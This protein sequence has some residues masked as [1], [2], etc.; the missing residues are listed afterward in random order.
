MCVIPRELYNKIVGAAKRRL[1]GHL[2]PENFVNVLPSQKESEEL[3]ELLKKAANS[4]IDHTKSFF[5][6]NAMIADYYK[7]PR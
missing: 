3:I 4:P 1:G 2:K 6:N 5:D 7:E